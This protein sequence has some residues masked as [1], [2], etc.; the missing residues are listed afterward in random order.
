MTPA[1]PFFSKKTAE[2]R[3]DIFRTTASRFYH[4]RGWS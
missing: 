4:G 1:I 2:L 3:G